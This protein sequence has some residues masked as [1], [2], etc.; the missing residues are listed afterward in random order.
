MKK[1]RRF[2]QRQKGPRGHER[3]RAMNARRPR[4]FN[5]PGLMGD[6][7]I[8]RE[9]AKRG[10]ARLTRTRVYQIRLEA[11]AK[12]RTALEEVLDERLS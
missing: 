7:Q 4:D 6:R 9:L 10:I 8:A 5:F 2:G 11:E 12:L 1:S 3:P